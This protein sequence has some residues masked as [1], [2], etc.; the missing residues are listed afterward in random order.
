MQKFCTKESA[1]VILLWNLSCIHLVCN[2]AFLEGLRRKTDMLA[3]AQDWQDVAWNFLCF[4][5][6]CHISSLS[7][8]L[9]LLPPFLSALDLKEKLLYCQSRFSHILNITCR[10]VCVNTK[11]HI[12]RVCTMYP[13]LYMYIFIDL[14]FSM[15][16][17]V[18]HDVS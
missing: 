12:H 7:Y 18:M 14:V 9:I 11:C 8:L 5:M 10:P 13:L 15:G 6:Q 17:D 16:N 4:D 2:I 1:E 3:H